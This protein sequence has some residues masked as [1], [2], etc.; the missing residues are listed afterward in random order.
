[1]LYFLNK[2]EIQHNSFCCLKIEFVLCFL[3]ANTSSER[4]KNMEEI[5]L[6]QLFFDYRSYFRGV[7][8]EG[9]PQSSYRQFI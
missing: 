5:W 1:V 4:G 3:G 2:F 7:F 9:Y 8:C 6:S